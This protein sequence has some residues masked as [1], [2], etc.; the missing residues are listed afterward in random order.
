MYFEKK[1]LNHLGISELGPPSYF[2]NR[3]QARQEMKIQDNKLWD[4]SNTFQ[5]FTKGGRL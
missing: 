1:L 5:Y 3:K 2:S 4:N